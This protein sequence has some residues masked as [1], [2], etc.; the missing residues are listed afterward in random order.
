MVNLP[1]LAKRLQS[2]GLLNKSFVD[3]TKSEINQ[4]IEAVF[5][6]I[7]EDVPRDGWKTP[8]VEHKTLV[9]PFDAHP[10]FHWWKDGAKSVREILVEMEIPYEIAKLYDRKLEQMTPQEWQAELEVPF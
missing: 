10:R 8:R 3:C 9:I 4:V 6:S 2:A 7:G 5:S 1:E